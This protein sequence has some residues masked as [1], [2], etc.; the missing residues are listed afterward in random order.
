MSKTLDAP[1]KY[2]TYAQRISHLILKP[3]KLAQY[4]G[5]NF[6]KEL[7]TPPNK[8]MTK[9]NTEKLNN[10]LMHT[11]AWEMMK[12]FGRIQWDNDHLIGEPKAQCCPA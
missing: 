11:L 2:V 3:M 12:T 6:A 9:W 4:I 7:Q 10:I 8:D 5:E 1:E